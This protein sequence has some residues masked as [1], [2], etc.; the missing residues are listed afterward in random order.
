MQQNKFNNCKYGNSY[1]KVFVPLGT[2]PINS[3]YTE[4]FMRTDIPKV[5]AADEKQ[6]GICFNIQNDI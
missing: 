4:M 1:W 6:S 2:L 5:M 3:N